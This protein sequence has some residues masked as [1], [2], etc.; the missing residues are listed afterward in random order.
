MKEFDDWYRNY[1]PTIHHLSQDE[2]GK[3][4]WKAALEWSLREIWNHHDNIDAIFALEK[5]LEDE[6]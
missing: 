2:Y 5:E 6:S 1:L 3:L 4:V